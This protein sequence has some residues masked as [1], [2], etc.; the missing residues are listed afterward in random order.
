MSKEIINDDS[1]DQVVG[2]FM[3]FNYMTK[4]LTYTHEENH[5][6][7]KYQIK[8]FEKAWKLSNALHAKNLHEDDII[9]QLINNGYI[10]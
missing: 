1:L 4:V 5:T 2:G 9:A 6:V 8:D 10:V 3:N 7:T